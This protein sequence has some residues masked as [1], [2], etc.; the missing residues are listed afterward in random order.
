MYAKQS[1]K[2]NL[3][4]ICAMAKEKKKRE[5]HYEPKVKLKEGTSFL[6]II[7]ASLG[8]KKKKTSGGIKKQAKG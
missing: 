5:A 6:D 7:D 4:Y 3:F 2:Q 1:I 8:L